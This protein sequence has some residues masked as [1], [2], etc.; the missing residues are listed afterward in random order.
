MKVA[1]SI[2]RAA[3]RSGAFKGK[4]KQIYDYL[5]ERTRGAIVPVRT[6]CLTRK[7]MMNGAHI[8]SDKTLREN[9]RHLRVIG[10]LDWN[11][12]TGVH[13]GNEYTVYLPEEAQE[14]LVTQST[15]YPGYPGY[16]GYFLPRVPRVVSTQGTQG[17]IALNSYTSEESKTLFKTSTERDDD[18]AALAGLVASLK[19]AAKDVTGK[20]TSLAESD[21][22]RE[23]AEVLV[24][25][26][27]I[28]A[29]RTTVSSAPAFLA[30]HLR[31]RLWKIDKKQARAE[32]K[33]LPDQATTV[34]PTEDSKG[35]QDC[36][37]SGWWYPNG[38]ERGVAKC[39]HE[40]LEELPQ[41]IT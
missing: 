21:R 24:A 40:R 19:K 9:L 32:G 27:K 4:S 13:E 33:E 23:L 15:L 11:E 28:A 20:E 16:P 39:R 37:G 18:D 1:N 25:E 3:M 14:T 26:M 6:V 5:Y 8:G 31:R 41:T 30:E 29:A 36:S 17:T 34:P 10:L 22:W 38:P 35:C 7:E 2:N 12:Q